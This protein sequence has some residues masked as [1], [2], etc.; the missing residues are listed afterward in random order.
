M[1]A[2]LFL[3]SAALFIYAAYNDTQ[4][5]LIPNWVSV[6]LISLYPIRYLVAPETIT[7]PLMDLAWMGGFFVV[8]F[9]F[10]AL[11]WFGAGDVKLITAGVLWFG[12]A[13]A[14][15]FLV[16]TA[17]GGA[18]I[19][20]LVIFVRIFGQFYWRIQEYMP[21][22]QKKEHFPYGLG[23]VIGALYALYVQGS[24]WGII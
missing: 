10:Y 12:H 23:I 4:T 5:M 13:H 6:A 3:L 7:D 11:K 9:I 20:L 15:D 21:A 1:L 24:V 16:G 18:L 17:F 14:P 2:I 8:G 19:A 22:L